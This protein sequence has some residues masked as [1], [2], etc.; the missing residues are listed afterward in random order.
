[1]SRLIWPREFG[2]GINTSVII[3][4]WHIMAAIQLHNVDV[5]LPKSCGSILR[6]LLWHNDDIPSTKNDKHFLYASRLRIESLSLGLT[7]LSNQP[8]TLPAVVNGSMFD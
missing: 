2:H 1:M 7:T 8:P 5:F 4:K 3:R 6:S